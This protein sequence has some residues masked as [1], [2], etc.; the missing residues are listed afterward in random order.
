M[1]SPDD[2]TPNV[3]T[4]IQKVGDSTRQL[5]RRRLVTGA[6]AGF[7][8]LGSRSVLANECYNPSETLSGARSHTGGDLPQCNGD[9]PGIWWQSAT[10]EGRQGGVDWFRL[11]PPLLGDATKANSKP[12]DTPF[13]SIFG[14]N[15]F[16]TMSFFEVLDAHR[17][18]GDL[19]AN[20]GFH[21]VGALLNIRAGW[22]DPRAMTEYYLVNRIWADYITVGYRPT[23]SSSTWTAQDIV[24]YLEATGI[25]S[26]Q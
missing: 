25:V 11:S 22:I 2:I 15:T 6:G 23:P 3:E 1:N 16:G 4:P 18:G 9:S 14:G 26:S 17:G 8:V 13:H 10:R 7:V 21:I 12:W 5:R 19:P 20:L 24:D